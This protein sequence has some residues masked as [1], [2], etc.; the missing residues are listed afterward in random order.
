MQKDLLP[1]PDEYV[2]IIRSDNDLIKIATRKVTVGFLASQYYE[3]CG[4]MITKLA[5]KYSVSLSRLKEILQSNGIRLVNP[6]AA[7]VRVASDRRGKRANPDERRQKN[8]YSIKS[9]KRRDGKYRTISLHR[10]VVEKE[11]GRELKSGEIVHH[12]NLDKSDNRYTNL[13]LCQPGEHAEIHASLW[14]ATAHLI[15]M[16][17]MFFADDKYCID[18]N[19]LPDD[20]VISAKYPHIEKDAI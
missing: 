16:G 15:Q 12:K 10:L 9:I 7:R 1:I 19:K 8:G 6:M 11:I 17:V 13:F 18:Y 5:D 20:V 4:G 3:E 14:D 2:D